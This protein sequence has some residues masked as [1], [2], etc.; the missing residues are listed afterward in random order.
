MAIITGEFNIDDLFPN[1]NVV[2]GSNEVVYILF[3]VFVIFCCHIVLMNVFTGL[4]VGDVATVMRIV[5][6]FDP[7][8]IPFILIYEIC[9]MH[10]RDEH[11][12]TIIIMT[13][14]KNAS[15]NRD[16]VCMQSQ[17]PWGPYMLA[18]GTKYVCNR[19][20]KTRHLCLQSFSMVTKYACYVEN[21]P[22]VT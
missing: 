12:V 1:G 13:R 17:K 18:K 5:S 7:N 10:Y 16:I 15:H 11:I 8:S 19:K 22:G 2:F 14:T 9:Y 21:L 4:A 20:F 3:L 6:F